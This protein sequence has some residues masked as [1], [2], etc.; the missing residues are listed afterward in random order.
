M[1]SFSSV[2]QRFEQEYPFIEHEDV[3]KNAGKN[4]AYIA[5]AKG[6]SDLYRFECEPF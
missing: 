6:V 2:S 4:Q 3:R 1:C 5:S